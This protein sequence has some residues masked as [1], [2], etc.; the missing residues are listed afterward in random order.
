MDDYKRLGSGTQA[1]RLCHQPH[2][3]QG[4]RSNWLSGT[5]WS[6]TI[7]RASIGSNKGELPERP[8]E[9]ADPTP[10]ILQPA[11]P[12]NDGEPP[13]ASVVHGF[14]PQQ[15][16]SPT[17]MWPGCRRPQRRNLGA[18]LPTPGNWPCGSCKQ[19]QRLGGCQPENNARMRTTRLYTQP[20]RRRGE[21][22]AGM[23][24]KEGETLRQISDMRGGQAQGAC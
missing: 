6:S 9:L 3:C 10:K 12:T 17:T 15:A 14:G 7:R 19:V 5:G 21:R 23:W 13:K 24:P 11:Q 1:L 18:T 4:T 2:L 22:Q 8:E 20:K 16:A